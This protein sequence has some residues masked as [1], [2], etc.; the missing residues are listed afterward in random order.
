MSL[1]GAEDWEI[2]PDQLDNGIIQAIVKNESSKAGDINHYA[3][4]TKGPTYG[5]LLGS[6]YGNSA[7]LED[8]TGVSNSIMYTIAIRHK[9][10]Y[11]LYISDAIY[12]VSI[13]GY[14]ESYSYSGRVFAQVVGHAIGMGH[15]HSHFVC[16]NNNCTKTDRKATDGS[17]CFDVEGIMSYAPNPTTW[18]KCSME[19]FQRYMSK[20]GGFCLSDQCMSYPSGNGDDD[21]GVDNNYDHNDGNGHA[22]EDYP[23]YEDYNDYSYDWTSDTFN[24]GCNN[25]NHHSCQDAM[26]YFYCTYVIRRF[27]LCH[28]THGLQF[29]R[30]TCGR[31]GRLSELFRCSSY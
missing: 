6:G 30:R 25:P 31:C 27:G 16:N 5:Y 11:L 10:V 2:I 17:S 20:Y 24:N 9:H 12:K 23:D 18:S 8:K 13:N 26:G 7:C 29:C 15:D 4:F 3:F 19:D 14:K 28:G 22:S 1:A 21:N